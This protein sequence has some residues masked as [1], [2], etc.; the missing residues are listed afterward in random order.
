M[1]ANVTAANVTHIL[2][3]NSE[4]LQKREK[5]SVPVAVAVTDC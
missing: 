4:A 3:E 1:T 2:P 5:R